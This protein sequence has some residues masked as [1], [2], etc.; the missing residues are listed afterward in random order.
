MRLAQSYSHFF[1][2]DRLLPPK[3][4]REKKRKEEKR[5]EASGSRHETVEVK[6]NVMSGGWSERKAPVMKGSA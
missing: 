2:K 1:I 5:K 3:G 6:R 4:R